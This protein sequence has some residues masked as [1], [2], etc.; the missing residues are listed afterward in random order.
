M[1]QGAVVSRMASSSLRRK[2]R[3]HEQEG[4]VREGMGGEEGGGC[5]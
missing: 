5:D 2:G 4:F 3:G 1:F